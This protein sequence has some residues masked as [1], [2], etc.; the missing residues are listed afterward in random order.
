[1]KAVIL[2]WLALCPLLVLQAQIEICDNAIDDDGDGLIDINDPDCICPE[3][4]PSGLIPNPS[5]EGMLCCPT[6]EAQFECAESWEQASA[7][8]SDYLH[9]C[10]TFT[11]PTWLD[12]GYMT[13]TP[14]PDGSGWVGFRDGNTNRPNYKEY[15]GA[16]L[17]AT[18][19]V[20]KT[21]RLDFYLGFPNKTTF[22]GFD[23]TFYGHE[24]CD[25]LP[26]GNGNDLIGCPLNT[27]G[28]TQIY[29]EPFTGR[30]EWI[31]VVAEFTA[32]KP[33][34]VF[35]LGS[36]CDIHPQ[37]QAQ[38]YFFVDRLAL[39]EVNEFDVPFAEIQGDI[40]Q[41]NLTLVAQAG[42]FTYQ[43]Y[44]DGIALVGETS[45][46]IDIAVEAASEGT[47]RVVFSQG[48]SCF[49]S[50]E[51]TLVVPI[52]E[53]EIV[54]EVCFGE[55]YDTGQ[56]LLTE[57]DVYQFFLFSQQGCDSTVT[58][59]LTVNEVYSQDVDRIICDGDSIIVDGDVLKTTGSYPY[60][61][62]SDD[63]CDSTVNI[64]LAVLPTDEMAIT[65]RICQ[66]ESYMVGSTPLTIT[67]TYPFT[68]TNTAGCDSTVT[69]QLIVLDTTEEIIPATICEG[70]AYVVGTDSLTTTDTY[71]FMMQSQ[72]GCDS[73]ITVVLTVEVPTEGSLENTLCLGD[74][75]ELLGQS[76]FEEGTYELVTANAAG[77]DSTI[78][79][80]VNIVDRNNGLSLPQDTVLSLGESLT[81]IPVVNDLGLTNFIWTAS[82][83]TP[84]E[85]SG[86]SATVT[87]VTPTT[88]TL[89]AEDDDGCGTIAD[90]MVRISRDIGIHTPNVFSP[91]GDG[92][93]EV[94]R[95]FTSKSV[96]S[97][98]K[99]VI[100]D[101]WG[102]LV[103]EEYN[104]ADANS[105]M[106]WAGL[107][108]GRRAAEGVYVYYAELT[109]KDAGQEIVSGDITLVR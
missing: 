105:M 82:D 84:I 98:D 73:F 99:L 53:T 79:L 2:I 72:Y 78:D 42:N 23:L 37:W 104:V 30:N 17:N 13:P 50:E 15:V 70:E 12:N 81:I 41:D 40:C 55:A 48:T 75:L 32:D 28:W 11:W 46:D 5:F 21:Y 95:I 103:Y 102:N 109:A 9:D 108:S 34:N 35:V 93:N 31:N 19:E 52:K 62:L 38:P 16:C 63:G 100:Y 25:V 87:P 43:W 26:F 91:N 6:F 4:V 61:Y 33:Y 97:L 101:R 8:T 29:Q 54:A 14:Y 10:G 3:E 57:T 56:Q 1:M 86:S 64:N 90:I 107:Y 22:D 36:G 65:P 68:F 51:Y 106:G 45:P 88:Y 74:T 89:I 80:T 66:G 69:V 18:M 92:Q 24:D 60:S 7:A 39:A 83:D 58:I 59:D 49:Y 27:P 44:K 96:A 47:Y 67:G 76:Y 20:G 77:C 85:Q 71:D 94:W